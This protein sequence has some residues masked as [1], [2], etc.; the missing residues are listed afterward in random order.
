MPGTTEKEVVQNGIK[1][2]KEH[3]NEKVYGKVA[4]ANKEITY[5][6][7]DT[8]TG[9]RIPVTTKNFSREENHFNFEEDPSK[10]VAASSGTE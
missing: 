7:Y 10:K 2:S 5:D 3:T 6:A 1:I 8:A 4:G 9:K